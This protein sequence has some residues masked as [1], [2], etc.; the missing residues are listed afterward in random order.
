MSSLSQGICDNSDNFNSK[1]PFRQIFRVMG[2]V[3]SL[4]V[5]TICISHAKD[6][7]SRSLL[8]SVEVLMYL[9]NF[10]LILKIQAGLPNIT[11]ENNLKY[12]DL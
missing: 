2:V 12:Q 5:L 3:G 7:F 8:T 11:N 1:S 10:V 4:R 6:I 9:L